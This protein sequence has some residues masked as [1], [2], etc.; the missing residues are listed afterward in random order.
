MKTIL[1]G[2]LGLLFCFPNVATA[3]T[4]ASNSFYKKYKK[5]DG[6]TNFT[7]PGW[8]IDM[9]GGIAKA[10]VDDADEKAA[11]K[12]LK[13]VQKMRFLVMEEENRISPLDLKALVTD[14]KSQAHEPLISIRDGAT[15]IQI[16]LRE[17]KGRLKYLTFLVSEPDEFVFL[18]LKTKIRMEDIN[19]LIEVMNDDLDLDI[20]PKEE[21]S[22]V[23]DQPLIRA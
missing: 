18:S 13:K 17:K 4:Q 12:L 11:I 8:V 16:L 9:V 23:S 21:K 2:F 19:R 6:T 14:L 10:S 1:I 3:Q 15:N 5:L 7:I 22:D 20:L